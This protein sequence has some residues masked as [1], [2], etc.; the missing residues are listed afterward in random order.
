MYLE[1]S[2]CY[3]KANK[4]ALAI[5]VPPLPKVVNC[6]QAHKWQSR[7][8]NN[9]HNQTLCERRLQINRQRERNIWFVKQWTRPFDVASGAITGGMKIKISKVT[10]KRDM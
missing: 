9:V 8:D 5:Y 1:D 6:H 10:E 4:F 3:V 7:V 2:S